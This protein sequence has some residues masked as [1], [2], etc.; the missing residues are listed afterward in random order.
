MNNIKY[1]PVIGIEIHVQIKTKFKAFT[2]ISQS[3]ENV[4]EISPNSL[5]NPFILGLPGTFPS[6]NFEAILN[7]IKVGLFFNCDIQKKFFWERKN[8]FYPD[9][10][11]GYQISQNV[12]PICKNGE[13][14]VEI[15]NPFKNSSIKYQKIRLKSIHLEEDA[16]KILHQKSND[17]ID[18]NRSGVSLM[19][20]VSKPHIKS[21]QEAYCFINSFKNHIRNLNISNCDMEKGQMRCDANISLITNSKKNNTKK[22]V[23]V[24][25]KNLNTIG[26]IKNAIDFE[27]SRQKKI[28]QENGKVL[29]Q[30]RK[31]NDKLKNTIP[32]RS[33][34]MHEGYRYFPDPDIPL[35]LLEKK[36]IKKMKKNIPENFIRKKIRFMKDHNLSYIVAST[37]CSKQ[38]L[39]EFYEKVLYFY[40]KLSQLIANFICNDLLKV[41]SKEKI[42]LKK[43]KKINSYSIAFLIKKI[44]KNQISRSQSQKIILKS[45]R[46]NQDL[47]KIAQD[48]KFNKISDK[49]ILKNYCKEVMKNNPKL[50]HEFLFGNKKVINFLKG[51]IMKKTKGKANFLIV[52]SILRKI[53]ENLKR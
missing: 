40:P 36:T 45:I 50:V 37:L 27:I 35:F 5:I 19:E 46:E 13:V 12:N 8:Y 31:Y 6:I 1:Q 25:I 42:P 51:I 28:L 7:V 39:S 22:G 10:P 44:H 32:M 43:I 53:L 4:G 30:S 20:V 34:E 18:L 33:K 9:L 2:K 16:G 3:I 29:R 17:L 21:S 41:F 47:I 49:E 52:D 38:L 11:K 15:S 23:R 14:L 24:E 26:G 48:K